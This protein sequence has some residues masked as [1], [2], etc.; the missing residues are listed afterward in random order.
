MTEFEMQFVLQINTYAFMKLE[1]AMTGSCKE[2]IT[3][4]L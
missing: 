4:Q 3:P 1:D 2:C